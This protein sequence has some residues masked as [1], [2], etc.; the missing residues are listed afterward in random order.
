MYW[1]AH[2]A[3]QNKSGELTQI[4]VGK[5]QGGNSHTK[6]ST[7]RQSVYSALILPQLISTIT[8]GQPTVPIGPARIS[9]PTGVVDPRLGS[10]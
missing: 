6:Y 3:R 5:W 2:E 4:K 7:H 8:L 10:N 9:Q 1:M